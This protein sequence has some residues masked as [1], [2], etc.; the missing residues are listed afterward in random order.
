MIY[1]VSPIR[2]GAP[3]VLQRG[4]R[5]S[6][7]TSSFL[8][9]TGD[10][11]AVRRPVTV[12]RE[13]HV[14]RQEAPWCVTTDS[15]KPNTA[16]KRWITSGLNR[17]HVSIGPLAAASGTKCTAPGGQPAP[18]TQLCHHHPILNEPEGALESEKWVTHVQEDTSEHGHIDATD[19]LR[20]RVNVAIDNTRSGPKG[21]VRQP[22]AVVEPADQY[23]SIDNVLP[24]VLVAG[25]RHYVPRFVLGKIIGNDFRST[26]LHLKAHESA[27]RTEVKD[28]LPSDVDRPQVRIDLRPEIPVALD[29]T[30][31]R[32]FHRVVEVA[33][34]EIRYDPWRS[35]QVA[36]R[37]RLLSSVPMAAVIAPRGRCDLFFHARRFEIRHARFA[38][39]TT[40]S[41]GLYAPRRIR[42]THRRR[43]RGPA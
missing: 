39:F 17:H 35:I 40:L 18:R 25:H 5:C 32:D 21:S 30:I 36:T 29:H 3:R 33:R 38:L 16:R 27:R 9:T 13:C 1:K 41:P 2:L 37:L 7:R 15:P 4:G 24:A 10:Q 19:S 20:N 14:P 23:L 42:T 26:R 6:G 34:S 31:A 28:A 43:R 11:R 12:N 8:S 22:E